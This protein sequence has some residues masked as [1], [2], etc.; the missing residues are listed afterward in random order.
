[1][2]RL[3]LIL[4]VVGLIGGIGQSFLRYEKT[5]TTIEKINRDS[6]CLALTPECGSCLAE[7]KDDKCVETDRKIVRGFPLTSSGSGQDYKTNQKLGPQHLINLLIFLLPGFL[8]YG[9]SIAKGK[10]K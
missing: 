5:F 7:I 9:V 3:A 6:L 1:M 10:K 2:K 4:L 8:L